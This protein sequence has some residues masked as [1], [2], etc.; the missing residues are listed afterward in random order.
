MLNLSSKDDISLP[1]QNLG[2][3][4]RRRMKLI[5]QEWNLFSNTVKYSPLVR[6]ISTSILPSL[7]GYNI[8]SSLVW[9]FILFLQKKKKTKP[10]VNCQIRPDISGNLTPLKTVGIMRCILRKL[11][12][13]IPRADRHDNKQC[14]HSEPGNLFLGLPLKWIISSLKHNNYPSQIHGIWSKV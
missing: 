8:S 3:Y 6:V 4:H 1:K 13:M 9:D 2:K 7:S 14:I 11:T 5:T 12:Y 10:G